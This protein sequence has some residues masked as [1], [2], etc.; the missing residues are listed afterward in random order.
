MRFGKRSG[1]PQHKRSSYL[2]DLKDVEKPEDFRLL[3]LVPKHNNFDYETDVD[4]ND[5]K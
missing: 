2:Y 3:A 1:K 5:E 4:Y